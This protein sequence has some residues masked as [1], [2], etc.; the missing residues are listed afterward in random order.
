M[1][2]N[3]EKSL[4]FARS[5]YDLI[6]HQIDRAVINLNQRIE[7]AKTEE[8]REALIKKKKETLEQLDKRGEEVLKEEAS[9][10]GCSIAD[11]LQ[12]EAST[13][14]HAPIAKSYLEGEE[15]PTEHEIK[16]EQKTLKEVEAIYN[17]N[18]DNYHSS[19]QVEQV[20]NEPKKEVL[21]TKEAFFSTFDFSSIDP[22]I[23]YDVIP[24][25]SGGQCYKHKKGFV[26]VSYVTASDENLFFSPNLYH[27]GKFIDI[28]LKRK[29]LDKD[30]VVE[31]LCVAD[32]DAIIL[33][34]RGDAYGPMIPLTI[35][36]PNNPTKSYDVTVDINEFKCSKNTLIGDEN[37]W[38]DYT[39][40][41]GDLIKFNFLTHTENKNLEELS[42]K[43]KDIIN[44]NIIK[45]SIST[46][47]DKVL[48]E[49]SNNKTLVTSI[50]NVKHWAETLSPSSDEEY[51]GRDI[52]LPMLYCIKAVNG[53]TDKTYIEKYVNNMRSLEAYKLR[54]YIRKNTPMYDFTFDVKRPGRG[55][56]FKSFLSHIN[57][58][59][60]RLPS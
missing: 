46:V 22:T 33:F 35:K 39:T 59:F 51:V 60:L 23:K 4:R 49:E 53:N 24:L 7:N 5:K 3:K 57:L 30:F 27:S 1:E 16:E 17:T 42:D 56:V 48:T 25:P 20:L 10:I 55:G 14:T 40:S 2:E 8:E 47:Y 11:I 19:T 29:I 21:D 9:I 32:K 36:D 6:L 13:F 58:I 54:E 28:L 43:E 44:I 12:V 37:G 34:L 45:N 50:E 26:P 38:F 31:D 18:T 41:T 15:P 52:T